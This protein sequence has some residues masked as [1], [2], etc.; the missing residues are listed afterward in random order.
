MPVRTPP[1]SRRWCCHVSHINAHLDYEQRNRDLDRPELIDARGRTTTVTADQVRHLVTRASGMLRAVDLGPTA[2]GPTTTSSTAWRNC[3]TLSANSSATVSTVWESHDHFMCTL[4]VLEAGTG[5]SESV[6]FAV[7]SKVTAPG[8]G[9]NV[10]ASF[11][12]CVGPA[13]SGGVVDGG[14]RCRVDCSYA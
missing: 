12:L 1:D 14:R 5:T 11:V 2:I 13:P 9:L 7:A 10:G 3:S 6:P 8:S 4:L